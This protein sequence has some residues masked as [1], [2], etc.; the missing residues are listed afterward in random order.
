MILMAKACWLHLLQ[1]AWMTFLASRGRA[2]TMQATFATGCHL[3][4][5]EKE[6]KKEEEKY[7]RYLPVPASAT[8]G[9][10]LT[11]M[12]QDLGNRHQRRGSATSPG[13]HNLGSGRLQKVSA[14][15][16]RGHTAVL[17]GSYACCLS[18][19]SLLNKG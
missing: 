15:G 5:W 18:W 1:R 13:L 6:D 14:P 9:G 10:G 16:S 11:S 17:A 19:T 2:V 7:I 8:F 12:C 3:H 4:V